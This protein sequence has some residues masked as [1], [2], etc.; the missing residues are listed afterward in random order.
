MFGDKLKWMSESQNATILAPEALPYH[1]WILNDRKDISGHFVQTYRHQKGG[2]RIGVT[3]PVFQ[4]YWCYTI[5]CGD[6]HQFSLVAQS[7]VESLYWLVDMVHDSIEHQIG[8][9]IYK[10]FTTVVIL[11]EQMHVI[12][13]IWQDFLEHLHYGHVQE[14]NIQTLHRLVFG[15]AGSKSV[16][17]QSELWNSASLITPRHAVRRLWN[18]QL[19]KRS[20]ESQGSI[21]I[22]A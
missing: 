10:E 3:R 11:K 22:S 6:L 19:L 17:F 18:K 16:D 12:D 20:V 2:H 15:R 1:W 4:W 7:H 13:P 5:L 21:Y 8:H 14:K 9:R